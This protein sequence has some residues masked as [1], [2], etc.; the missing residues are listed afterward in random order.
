LQGTLPA[1]NTT[2]TARDAFNIVAGKSELT[3][4]VEYQPQE[5]SFLKY[6][7]GSTS[8]AATT[9]YYPQQSATLEADKKK[10]L[11]VP[12]IAIMER[13]D[14]EGAGD[15]ANT[16]LKFLGLKVNTWSMAASIGEPV[17]CTANLMG[18]DILFD[19]T[20]VSTNYPFTALSSNDIFHFVES[21]V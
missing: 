20:T 8:T 7:L 17:K 18:S 6:V 12:S 1:L 9:V 19:Q 13:F 4:D 2:K 14:F 11:T 3:V 21:E 10:Y 5:F 15:S 16:A